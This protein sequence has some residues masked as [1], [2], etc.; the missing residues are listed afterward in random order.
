MKAAAFP[1]FFI[2]GHLK[3][4]QI[5]VEV[6]KTKWVKGLSHSKG[7]WKFTNRPMK[8]GPEYLVDVFWEA[9]G[10]LQ[11]K[12]LLCNLTAKPLAWGHLPSASIHPRSPQSPSFQ[13]VSQLPYSI[14]PWKT[15]VFFHSTL[16]LTLLQSKFIIPLNPGTAAD[17]GNVSF[18]G[19]C[20]PKPSL[21]YFFHFHSLNTILI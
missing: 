5:S 19:R 9:A 1:S 13:P 10:L 20:I 11:S 7:G 6:F 12:L 15:T 18:F 4:A 2:F 14:V 16:Y 17:I 3:L 8:S 21:I